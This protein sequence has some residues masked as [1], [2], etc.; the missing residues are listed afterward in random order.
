[1]WSNSQENFFLDDGCYGAVKIVVEMVR[2]RLQGLG[3]ISELLESLKEPKEAREI[4]VRVTAEDVK[5]EAD[6]VT[7]AFKEWVD[8][9]GCNK[10]CGREQ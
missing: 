8:A 10:M 3:D 7:A 5:P 9:G 4:R 1:M 6:K 2:R